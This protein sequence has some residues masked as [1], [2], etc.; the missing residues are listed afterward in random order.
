[1]MLKAF[2]QSQKRKRM[3][4][5][6]MERY[7]IDLYGEQAYWKNGGYEAFV[8]SVC[9]LVNEGML[10]PVKASKWNGKNPSLYNS[11][12][13]VAPSPEL[14]PLR[15]AKLLTFY[16][17]ELQTKHYLQH[18]DQYNQDE[19]YI[20]RIDQFFK[21]QEGK[22]SSVPSM[23]V[24]ERSFELFQ[25]E[26]WLMSSH[27][28]EVLGK[29]N[30]TWE[31]L[32]CYPTYEPFFYYR[33]GVDSHGP[34]KNALIV[35]NKDTFF[36]LKSLFQAGYYS[37][38]DT[39]FDLLIY[40]EGHKI[41]K[42][43]AFFWELEE[44]RDCNMQFYYFGDLDPEGIAIWHQ[45]RIRYEVTIEPFAFFYS[46]LVQKYGPKAPQ[47]PRAQRCSEGAKSTFLSYF[48]MDDRLLIEDI[49]TQNQYL[50]QEGLHIHLLRQLAIKDGLDGHNNMLVKE[51][52]FD[53]GRQ[54]L[55]GGKS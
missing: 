35:E 29:L 49:L 10:R 40:G 11:Y 43:F 14:D 3:E 20:Q 22:T 9:E 51:S 5:A 23:T 1:M 37:W 17:P 53:E 13:W 34:T 19:W 12:Q 6:V 44:Y 16:H 26:K 52:E 55:E 27:G 36:S 25:D 18:I 15:K 46:T 31:K 48:P 47:R 38:N 4:T 45:L 8:Q 32:R 41:E 42:S 21:D 54:H 24:N 28:K 39:S 50:P 33:R 7:L 30:V 2:L